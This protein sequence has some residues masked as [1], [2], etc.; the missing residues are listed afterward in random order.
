[1]CL[2]VGNRS[3]PLDITYEKQKA[4]TSQIWPDFIA[5]WLELQNTGPLTHP[6][7]GPCIS[8]ALNELK[9]QELEWLIS[10]HGDKMK[11]VLRMSFPNAYNNEAEYGAL[12]HDMRMAKACGATCLKIFGDSN[13]AA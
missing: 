6:V 4:I 8:M 10:P 13:L 1:M 3:S 11:S 2:L 5:E 7:F 12:L 9:E